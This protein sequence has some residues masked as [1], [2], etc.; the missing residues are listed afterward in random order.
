MQDRDD[1]WSRQFADHQQQDTDERDPEKCEQQ[2]TIP[3]NVDPRFAHVMSY[4]LPRLLPK[5]SEQRRL[6]PLLLLQ[7]AFGDRQDQQG[8]DDIDN[9]DKHEEHLKGKDLYVN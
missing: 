9:G 7:S 2:L 6:R 3:A 5:R 1:E 8:T 4:G